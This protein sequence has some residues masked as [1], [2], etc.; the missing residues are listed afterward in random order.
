MADEFDEQ[1]FQGPVIVGTMNETDRKCPMCGGIMDF[2]P[3]LGQLHCPFC[4]YTEEIKQEEGVAVSAEEQDFLTAEETGNCNWGVET[5]TV[6]CKSCA[7]EMVYDA[8]QSSGECPYCGSN[9]VME[10]KGKNTLAPGGVC[11]F[12]VDDQSA[13]TKFKNWISKKWF[14]PRA[15]KENAKPKDMKGVYLPYWTFDT[16]TSSSYTAEYGISRT[17]KRSDGSTV[18]TTD[19]SRCSGNY[20][21]FVDDKPVC[22]TGRYNQGLLQGILPFDTADNKTYKPEYVAGFASERYSIGLKDAWTT[23]KSAIQSDLNNEITAL[24]RKEHNADDVR[25]LKVKTEFGNI[26]YKYLL[27]PVWMAHFNYNGKVYN[28]MVNGQNGKVAGKIPVSAAKV[29][30]AIGIGIA[31]CVALW[32]L[33]NL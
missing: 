7:G 12:K 9:Q 17:E 5:K 19:W 32:F 4:D 30:L 28:F 3:N 13:A 26:K 33:V 1:G 18:T 11:T 23:G 16:N 31:A 29:A 25:S 14:C 27:L 21:K 10:A 8:L 20:E 22:G 6:I 2:D 24:I 15:A